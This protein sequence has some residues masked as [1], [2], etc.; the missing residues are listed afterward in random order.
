MKI[1]RREYSRAPWRLVTDAGVEVYAQQR[2]KHPD[3]GWTFVD[4]PVCGQTKAEC[5]KNALG[6]LELLMDRQRHGY[7]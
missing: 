2:F 6:L 5:I 1:E 4:G 3:L 7:G